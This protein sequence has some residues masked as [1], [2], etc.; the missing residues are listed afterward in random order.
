MTSLPLDATGKR[1]AFFDQSGMDQLLSIVLELAAD[2]WVV[3]ERAFV[4]ESVL[5]QQGIGAR[6]AVESY[7]PT[8]EVR[9]ELDAMRAEM[10]ARMFRTLNRDHRPV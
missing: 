7:R 5:Q 10:T 3:R 2:L 9:A 6:A 8:A 4:L 1:P